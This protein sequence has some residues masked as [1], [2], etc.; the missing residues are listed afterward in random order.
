MKRCPKCNQEFIEEW[1]TFCTIDGTQLTEAVR[2]ADYPPPTMGMP[3]RPVT[4]PQ[5]ERPTMRMPPQPGYGGP[6]G[7]PQQ[8]QPVWQPPPP[9]YAMGPRQDMAVAALVSG[10]I[11]ITIGW[12]WIGLLTGPLA[13]GLGIY[14]LVQIKNN[15]NQFGGKPLAIAGLVTGSLFL[16][17]QLLLLLFY[18]LIFLGGIAGGR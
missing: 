5:E 13:V 18:G 7:V 11:S 2:S 6:L 9:P 1:L 16:V 15:P 14:A 3:P 17:V 10:L 12:C 8:P 4:A